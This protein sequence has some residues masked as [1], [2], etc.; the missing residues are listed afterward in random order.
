MKWRL[1]AIWYILTSKSILTFGWNDD[2]GR[3]VSKDV[4]VEQAE[5]MIDHLQRAVDLAKQESANL[6]AVKQIINKS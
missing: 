6:D 3:Y 5:R 2:D 1:K 4:Y